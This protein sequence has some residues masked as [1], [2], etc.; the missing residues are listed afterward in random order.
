MGEAKHR[1]DA[2]LPP[3]GTMGRMVTLM[4]PVNFVVDVK[5]QVWFPRGGGKSSQL[6][7]DPQVIDAVLNKMEED[8]AKNSEIR[9]GSSVP[10]SDGQEDSNDSEV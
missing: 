9:R 7:Q 5:G 4:M 3:R 1:R 6:V 10:H 2:G 8:N